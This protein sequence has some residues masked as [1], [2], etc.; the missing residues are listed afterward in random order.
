MMTVMY[1]MNT[2]LTNVQV[3]VMM[4]DIVTKVAVVNVTGAPCMMTIMLTDMQ[5]HVMM[6]D[7]VTKVAVVNMTGAQ[8]MMTIIYIVNTALTDSHLNIGTQEPMIIMYN[9]QGHMKV[10]AQAMSIM[11]V[12]NTVHHIMK[13]IVQGITGMLEGL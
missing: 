13:S 10:G 5:V 6:A 3:Q 11:Y 8:C 4:A 12:M 1:I 2:I 9:M 7:I